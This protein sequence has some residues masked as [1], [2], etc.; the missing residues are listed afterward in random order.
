MRAEKLKSQ[1]EAAGCQL[2]LDKDNIRFRFAGKQIPDMARPLL[3]DLKKCKAEMVALLKPDMIEGRRKSLEMVADAILEQAVIDINRG[4][5]WQST[6]DV[7]ALEDE[8]NRLDRL[9]MEGLSTIQ[10]FKEIV[11][12]WRH[13]GTQIL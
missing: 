8:I 6:P 3:D 7:R 1:L 5:V 2:S 9:L 10:A 11:D 4:G 12:K 13:A